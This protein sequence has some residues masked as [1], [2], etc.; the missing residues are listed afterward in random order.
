MINTSNFRFL[1]HVMLSIYVTI[2]LL[3]PFGLDLLAQEAKN[4]TSLF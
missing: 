2:Q 1:I 3:S 4:S